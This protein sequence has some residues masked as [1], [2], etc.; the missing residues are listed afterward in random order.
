MSRFLPRGQWRLLPT[1]FSSRCSANITGLPQ[2]S[3]RFPN[4]IQA[5]NNIGDTWIAK[6]VVSQ[7]ACSGYLTFELRL[8]F[9]SERWL[10]WQY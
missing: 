7:T 9:S 4:E 2:L 3:F 5:A 6:S 1:R 10:S 8:V